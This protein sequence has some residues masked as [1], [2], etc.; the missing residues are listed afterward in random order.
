[1]NWVI[2]SPSRNSRKKG[3]R[4]YEAEVTVEAESV[5]G[6]ESWE[7]DPSSGS[8][9]VRGVAEQVKVLNEKGFLYETSLASYFLFRS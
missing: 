2:S 7:A 6:G 1:M 8:I 3:R 5:L 4:G 9:I